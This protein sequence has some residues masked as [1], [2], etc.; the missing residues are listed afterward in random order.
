MLR[1][2]HIGYH[3]IESR[4]PGTPLPH[5]TAGSLEGTDGAGYLR[6]GQG[7]GQYLETLKTL[8]QVTEEGLSGEFNGDAFTDAGSAPGNDGHFTFK[9]LPAA[10]FQLQFLIFRLICQSVRHH[11]THYLSSQP[12]CLRIVY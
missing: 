7:R 9:Q 10:C 1:K 3:F 2:A 5:F 4:Y 6:F 8:P 12:R 11:L